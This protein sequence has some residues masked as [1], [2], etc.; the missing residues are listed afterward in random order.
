MVLRQTG[1]WRRGGG[2]FGTKVFGTPLTVDRAE[3]ERKSK[4]VLEGT[5][6]LAKWDA[7]VRQYYSKTG[8]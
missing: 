1:H 8:R 6:S 4:R 7:L 3:L 2:V 5:K